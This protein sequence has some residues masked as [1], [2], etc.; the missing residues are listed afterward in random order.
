MA[1]TSTAYT[2][3]SIPSE[4]LG[5]DQ[6]QADDPRFGIIWSNPERMSGAPCFFGTRVPVQTL[7]DFIEAGET[8]DDFVEGFPPIT[9]EHVLAILDLAKADLLHDGAGQ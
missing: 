7:F 1:T 9:R 4:L 3:A 8:I 5:G 2:P 6:I